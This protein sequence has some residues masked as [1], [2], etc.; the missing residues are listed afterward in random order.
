M[1]VR[2]APSLAWDLGEAGGS[3]A[4]RMP[5]HPVALELLAAVGPMAVSSANR[6]GEP[7]AQTADDAQAQL[8]ESVAV[9]LDGGPT[10]GMV[11]S[12]IVD[13][14]GHAPRVLRAGA[15][16]LDEIRAVVPRM[17]VVG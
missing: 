15:L 3:V 1:V 4:L 12:T 5:L 14:T 16:D 10:A 6:S 2:Q 7:P 8:G 17:E 9:Y 13:L 11:P